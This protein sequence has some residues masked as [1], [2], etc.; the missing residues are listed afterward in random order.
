MCYTFPF[1]SSFSIVL[2]FLQTFLEGGKLFRLTL[3]KLICI[4]PSPE[5]ANEV[6][7]PGPPPQIPPP[8]A[9]VSEHSFLLSSCFTPNFSAELSGKVPP[10]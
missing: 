10:I 4:A 9:S 8:A 6:I 7:H 3:S 5:M 2:Y 1:I